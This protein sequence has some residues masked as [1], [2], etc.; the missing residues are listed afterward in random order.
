M[1]PLLLARQVTHRNVIRIFDLGVADG[2][3]FI[4]V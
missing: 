3:H 2:L 1:E 4:T